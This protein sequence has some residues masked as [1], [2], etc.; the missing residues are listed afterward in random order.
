MQYGRF[1][2]IRAPDPLLFS[3]LSPFSLSSENLRISGFVQGGWGWGVGCG[4]Y[5]PISLSFSPDH[6]ILKIKR[7]E[8]Y[9]FY[10]FIAQPNTFV[11]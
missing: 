10:F 2:V 11:Q 4:G 8:L 7:E 9:L 6:P 1:G 5:Q 3:A